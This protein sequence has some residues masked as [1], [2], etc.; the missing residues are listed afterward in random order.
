M[1]Y[2][3]FKSKLEFCSCADSQS[4]VYIN[5]N[6]CLTKNYDSQEILDKNYNKVPCKCE[7][8]QYA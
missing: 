8:K 1:Q 2:I 7:I 4:Q 5:N 3:T 6:Y